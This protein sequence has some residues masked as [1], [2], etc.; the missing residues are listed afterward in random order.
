MIKHLPKFLQY[1]W[2]YMPFPVRKM[3]CGSCPR[4]LRN[5]SDTEKG[6]NHSGRLAPVNF[7]NGN[8]GI[9]NAQRAL[10]Y[11]R[12]LTEFISQ[13]EYRNL[14]PIFG[15]VNEPLLGII[16]QDQLTSFYLEAHN[17]IRS[18][19]GYGAGNGPVSQVSKAHDLH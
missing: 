2:T 4:F 5:C 15:I 9:A 6:Y 17:M 18:I 13:P 11:I 19:T 7:L 12:I 1:A 10:Y 14:I 3:V 8:M 16:G